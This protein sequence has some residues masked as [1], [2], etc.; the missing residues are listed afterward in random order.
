MKLV[1]RFAESQK[2]LPLALLALFALVSGMPQAKAQ[3]ELSASAPLSASVFV[4]ASYENPDDG[5]SRDIG[6]V[7]GGAVTR[8]LHLVQPGIDVRYARVTGDV[9]DNSDF[10]GQLKVAKALG[11]GGQLQPYLLAGIGYGTVKYQHVYT[12]N[13]VIYA[14]GGG[15]DYSFT[16]HFGAKADWEYQFWNLGTETH[17]LNPSGFTAGITY[18]IGLRR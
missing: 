14:I 4:A 1:V 10:L 3:A 12:D 9:S 6:Y 17:G 16:S 8:N 5:P 18:R 2:I 11:R 7:V 15:L 13:S